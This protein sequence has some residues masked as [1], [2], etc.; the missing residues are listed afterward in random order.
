MDIEEVRGELC[1]GFWQQI[2]TIFAENSTDKADKV[3]LNK[4]VRCW[5]GK[6]TAKSHEIPKAAIFR[7]C[8]ENTTRQHWSQR[9]RSEKRWKSN[10]LLDLKRRC[11][12]WPVWI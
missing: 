2:H 10:D 12:D 1:S 11:M 4:S 8:D 9:G 7:A 3:Q 5:N 6:W